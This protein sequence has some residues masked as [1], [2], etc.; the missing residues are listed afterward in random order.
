MPHITFWTVVKLVA[1]SLV[2]GLVLDWLDL[3]PEDVLALVTDA[4][5]DLATSAGDIVS[6][7]ASYVLLGAV[8]VVPLWLIAQLW[9]KVRG[10]L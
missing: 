1:A 4:A 3:G 2:V 10:R 5:R 6:R 9:R 7:T 8:I